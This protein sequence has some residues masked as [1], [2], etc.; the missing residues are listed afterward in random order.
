MSYAYNRRKKTRKQMLKL[1][2]PQSRV[3]E[4]CEKRGVGYPFSQLIAMSEVV[5]V[6]TNLDYKLAN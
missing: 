3:R 2:I 1:G 4:F 5:D 6:A